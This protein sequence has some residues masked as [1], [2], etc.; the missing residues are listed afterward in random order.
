MGGSDRGTPFANVRSSPRAT[1]FARRRDLP[2]CAST[3]LT[4]HIAGWPVMPTTEVDHA[5]LKLSR[6]LKNPSTD[7]T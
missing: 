2:L 6:L 3:G 1:E 7:K 4:A 5:E